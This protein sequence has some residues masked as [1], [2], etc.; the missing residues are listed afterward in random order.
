MK[1]FPVNMKRIFSIIILI[2]L[3]VSALAYNDTLSVKQVVKVALNHVDYK[4]IAEEHDSVQFSVGFD[5]LKI[6]PISSRKDSGIFYETS[7]KEGKIKSVKIVDTLDNIVNYEFGVFQQENLTFLAAYRH[8]LGNE[9]YNIYGF[10]LLDSRAGKILFFGPL[11]YDKPEDIEYS[12]DQIRTIYEVDANLLPSRK[13][14]FLYKSLVYH[15][16][17]IYQDNKIKEKIWQYLYHPDVPLKGC[18]KYKN[19]SLLKLSDIY[20]ILKNPGLCPSN[21]L[22]DVEPKEEY[23][24][25]KIPFLWDFHE[26]FHK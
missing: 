20:N 4:F 11:Y 3:V 17:M 7:Y 19:L 15:T 24:T 10:F 5:F 22:G 23:L 14:M 21:L 6:Q 13:L 2:F 9:G 1:L 8:K 25:K 18:V 16:E 12:I 26:Y